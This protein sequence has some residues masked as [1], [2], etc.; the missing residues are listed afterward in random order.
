MNINA[1]NNAYRPNEVNSSS[2]I[3]VNK[4]GEL[5]KSVAEK[6]QQ[7]KLSFNESENLITSTEREFFIKMFPENQAQLQNHVLFNRNGR[8][9]TAAINKG[10]IIDGRV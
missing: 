4:N 8:L 6:A 3:S 1:I 9:Q 5:S 10:S 2:S 7:E